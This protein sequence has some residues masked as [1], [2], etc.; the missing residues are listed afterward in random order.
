MSN[1]STFD[2]TKEAL[3]DF[4]LQ[5]QQG[6]IQLP[7]LQRS[8]CW[9]D[10]LIKELL[11]SVS[12]AWPVGAVLLLEMGNP[13]VKFR[14]R[15][16]EGVSLK[17]SPNPSKLIL[18][19][20]QRGTSLFQALFSNQPV[21]LKEK[22]GKKLAVRW[23]YID[24]EKALNPD[25]ER[26]EAI[27]ALP[28]SRI[29]SGFGINETL[30]CST[31]EKEYESMM[32][33]VNKVFQYS[34]WRSGYSKFW[35]YEPVKLARID[36]FELEVVKKFEH[37]QMPVIQLRPSL[38]KEAICKIFEKINTISSEL[39]FFDL[40]TAIYAAEDFSLR[41]DWEEKA[42]RLKRFRV[43]GQ[44]RNLDFLQAVTL[45]TSYDR[46]QEALSKG[47]TDKLP[48]VA[49]GRKEVLGLALE[50]YQRW[51]EPIVRAY[52]EAARFLHGQKIFDPSDLP[53]PIQLVALVAVLCVLGQRALHDQVRSKLER[54][55]WVGTFGGMYAGWHDT[56]AVRDLL[57][58]PAWLSGG[59]TLPSTINEANFSPTRLTTIR[60]RHGSVYKGFSAL[61][62]REGAIDFSTGEALMDVKFFNDPIESHHIFPVAYCRRMGIEAS[63]YNCLINRTPLSEGT[64]RLIGGKAPSVYLAKLQQQGISKKRLDEI[65]RSHLI[66]PETLWNDDFEG[67]FAARTQALLDLIGKVMGKPCQ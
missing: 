32:F 59:T 4:L 35:N 51:A 43:L 12:M 52:E 7:D 34:A 57:E 23:Y 9:P 56:R 18:D 67:F 8:F 41:D 22:E 47:Q 46:R 25:V 39:N 2:I 65:V 64:N 55:W 15:L 53:Y 26:E 17:Q 21:L 3:P 66:E 33:P 30:D 5:I 29:K 31:E 14:P 50:E 27:I 40:A 42:L 20:Q 11:A 28:S 24:I 62:R 37:Y 19:G 48:G 60:R 44:V 16:V 61:L 1:I 49:C 63:Q 36:R 13:T 58:L 45:A 10:E 38:P 6:K 54:W